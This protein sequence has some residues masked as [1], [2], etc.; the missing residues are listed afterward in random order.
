M[1]L[2]HEDDRGAGVGRAAH[3]EALLREQELSGLSVRSFALSRGLSPVT[4]YLWRGKL[5]RT[6]A[7]RGGAVV[8]GGLVAVKVVDRRETIDTASD[9]FEISLAN[10][11]GVRVPTRFD[12]ARLAELLAVLR[13]C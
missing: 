3:Y 2:T 10:G 11:D 6:R 7:R 1:K 5:G 8:G 9:G 12:A 13:A 4:L